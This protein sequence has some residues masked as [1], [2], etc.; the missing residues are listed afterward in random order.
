[1]MI[2]DCNGNVKKNI[3]NERRNLHIHMCIHMMKCKKEKG[4]VNQNY[5]LMKFLILKPLGNFFEKKIFVNINNN[6]G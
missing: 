5:K 4:L 2:V 1:M 3:N 6:E